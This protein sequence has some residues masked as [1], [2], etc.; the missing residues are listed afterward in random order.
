MRLTFGSFLLDQNN[1]Q[2]AKDDAR[3]F[4]FLQFRCKITSFFNYDKEKWT[5]FKEKDAK[6]A[7]SPRFCVFSAAPRFSSASRGLVF[8]EGKRFISGCAGGL[9]FKT[10]S[11]IITLSFNFQF[12]I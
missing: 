1:R 12:S 10:F 11:R 7:E 8:A 9:V 2:Q 5:F 6:R 3:C 4:H